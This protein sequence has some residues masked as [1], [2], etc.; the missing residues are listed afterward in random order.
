MIVAQ[1]IG[2]ITFCDEVGNTI[3]IDYVP[4]G[5]QDE[6]C[7]GVHPSISINGRH[8]KLKHIVE[9]VRLGRF[10]TIAEKE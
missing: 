3:K 1:A 5:V 6:T 8:V 10:L 4:N 7:L 2:S 9:L